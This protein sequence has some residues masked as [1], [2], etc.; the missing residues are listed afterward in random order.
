LIT[1]PNLAARRGFAIAL[2]VLL[3]APAS[4][5]AQQIAPAF[6]PHADPWVEPARASMG[7]AVAFGHPDDYRWE[8]A[9]VG[10]MA[11]GLAGGIV[12]VAMCSF[13][14]P[15]PSVGC[16]LGG[17]LLGLILGGITGGGVGG[18]VGGLI[19]KARRTP[20]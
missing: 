5:A 15:D 14:E 7:A 17:G 1:R 20:E 19:P 2:A 18:L 8:G 12:G 3:L 9:L 4:G 13:D 16:V 11:G 10:A 6:A